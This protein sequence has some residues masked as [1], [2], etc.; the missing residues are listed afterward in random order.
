MESI[1]A[2]PIWIF[3]V[4]LVM[5]QAAFSATGLAI[6]RYAKLRDDPT[7]VP[8][9]AAAAGAAANPE[10]HQRKIKRLKLFGMILY[11]ASQPLNAVAVT[12]CPISVVGPLCSG[13]IIVFSVVCA[14][15]LGEVYTKIDMLAVALALVGTVG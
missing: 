9:Q 2:V 13:S 10:R 7:S 4:A 1:A 15:F 8:G 3:G 6:Q 5:C 14:G 12:I 11:G